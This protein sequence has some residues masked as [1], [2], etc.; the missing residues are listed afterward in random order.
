MSNSNSNAFFQPLLRYNYV[1]VSFC[2][3]Q[4]N[5]TACDADGVR[6]KSQLTKNVKQKN[7]QQAKLA[8]RSHLTCK[9]MHW[10]TFLTKQN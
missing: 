5:T 3:K 10:K 1:T 7:R 9:A 2:C 4:N 6:I 8:D